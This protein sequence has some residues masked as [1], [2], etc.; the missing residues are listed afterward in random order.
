VSI[1]AQ[2]PSLLV[3]ILT[4]GKA[5]TV[6]GVTLD[7]VHGLRL[8]VYTRRSGKSVLHIMNDGGHIITHAETHGIAQSLRP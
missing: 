3:D 2:K 1:T 8:S 7:E 6:E 5:G 4:D